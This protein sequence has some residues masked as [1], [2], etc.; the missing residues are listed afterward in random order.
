MPSDPI[1]PQ[2]RS[3]RLS[4]YDYTSERLTL[5]T[6]CTARRG[7]VLGSV[8][9]AT[10]RLNRLGVLTATSLRGVE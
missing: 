2:R 10:V 9:D 3:L 4:S 6:F 5:V 7:N 8:V 1:R